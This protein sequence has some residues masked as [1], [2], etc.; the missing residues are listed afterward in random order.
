M[1][2]FLL[3]VVMNIL[4]AVLSKRGR[5]TA[6]EG[7]RRGA[8]G[9]VAR[10]EELERPY[11]HEKVR[12]IIICDFLLFLFSVETLFPFSPL[13]FFISCFPNLPT[14]TDVVLRNG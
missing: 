2:S 7:G 6:E 9:V 4:V 12:V 3:V 8:M 14:P 10:D 11:G 5:Y 1:A 13:I